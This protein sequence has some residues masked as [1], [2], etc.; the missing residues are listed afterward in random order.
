MLL[1]LLLFFVSVSLSVTTA[2]ESCG[3]IILG[4]EVLRDTNYSPLRGIRTAILTNPTGVF[5]D[6]LQ[7]IVDVMVTTS[8]LNVVAI[9]SPEHGFRGEKQAETGDPIFYI[10]QS[11]KLPVYSAYNMSVSQITSVMDKMTIEAVL[12]DMQDV[13]VRLYTFIWTMYNVLAATAASVRSIKF[14]VTDRP[15]PLGGLLVEG[16]Q[17]DMEC[18]ASGYGRFPIPF[19]HGMTIGELS[20]LFNSLIKLPSENLIVIP[21]KN[22]QRNYLWTN[23]Q[24]I[25]SD[26]D[27]V[28]CL[29]GPLFPE[30]VPPS[31]NIPTPTSAQA[32]AATVFLEATTAAE[33]RGTTTPFELFGAPFV[34]AEVGIWERTSI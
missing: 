29:V 1:F 4:N 19:I 16:P 26:L 22:W 2:F 13:G 17:I 21:M 14:V 6:N 8:G 9:F 12:T 32:Y 30:W 24:I 25:R 11:T 34:E 20:L 31:P 18:C 10:D 7:H 5:A 3:R 33:G 27:Q 28:S 15:N 23:W